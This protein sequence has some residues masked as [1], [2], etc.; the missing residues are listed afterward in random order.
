MPH[1]ETAGVY[2]LVVSGCVGS[3]TPPEQGLPNE[4]SGRGSQP[5][6]LASK[7]LN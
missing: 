1:L 3:L 4:G 5:G 7:D 2:G 6:E